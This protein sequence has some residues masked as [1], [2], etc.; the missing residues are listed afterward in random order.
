MSRH[1][2]LIISLHADPIQPSGTSFGGGTHAYIRELIREITVSQNHCL[3]ITRSTGNDQPAVQR[4]SDFGKICRIVIGQN[5]HMDKRFLNNFHKET[6]IAIQEVLR[7][8]KFNPNILHSV[9]WNSGRAAYDLSK[10]LR[11]PYVHTV[12]SN[13]K[14]RLCQGLIDN[15]ESR[16]EIERIVFEKAFAIISI[17][18][19]EKKDLVRFYTIPANKIFVV[20][21]PVAASFITPSQD[22]IGEPRI[23]L[24][25]CYGAVANILDPNELKKILA[26]PTISNR[27]FTYVGRIDS[28][29][30][31]PEIIHA[32]R[33]L[34]QIY[35]FRCPGL[36][37]IGGNPKDIQ[38]FR[39]SAT[40]PNDLHQFET[41]SDII[42][43]GYLDS[44]GISA[45]LLKAFA[46]V[47]HSI[48]E[49]G[50]RVIL[51]AMSQGVPVIATPFG[52]AH[53]L[54]EDWVSG[55]LVDYGDNRTLQ[56]RLDHFIQQP[57]L[58]AAL[59][60]NAKKR[61]V[62]ALK[63]WDFQGKHFLLY[64]KAI[65]RGSV[66]PTIPSGEIL[67]S[68]DV[69]NKRMVLPQHTNI[70]GNSIYKA[71]LGLHKRI[72]GINA[73]D[74]IQLDSIAGKA[75]C[76]KTT[77]GDIRLFFK[78][79]HSHFRE[80][81]LWL[82]TG[83]EMLVSLA[84]E[85]IKNEISAS[86]LPG[87]IKIIDFD[88]EKLLVAKHWM[89][90]V[91]FD[92]SASDCARIFLAP[93]KK[94]WK[95]DVVYLSS[96]DRAILEINYPERYSDNFYK[97]IRR[98]RKKLDH[99]SIKNYN[100]TS[101]LSIFLWVPFISRQISSNTVLL[102]SDIK[103]DF[104]SIL[105]ILEEWIVR[106]KEMPIVFSHGSIDKNHYLKTSRGEIFITDGETLHRG[107]WGR[108]AG[109]ILRELLILFPTQPVSDFLPLL[110]Q[111]GIRQ[112]LILAWAL[113]VELNCLARNWTLIFPDKYKRAKKR[114]KI[115]VAEVS[116][117]NEAI[118]L[119]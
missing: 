88:F 1:R 56:Q 84:D 111:N 25:P 100:N 94:L 45:V 20:G 108:D 113:L 32:W 4:I 79:F 35:K 112:R 5:D 118:R 116:K 19:Q 36:W 12:I 92:T 14:R 98:L 119:S 80:T 66:L 42:W 61:A 24:C 68:T 90:G 10:K 21:R 106:E 48:Y 55:F 29:K 107:F 33:N 8:E 97:I 93:L 39:H 72:T 17:T 9:Y 114:W 115:L 38:K 110:E 102:E 47:T 30:G 54:I 74:I 78:H 6:I 81:P 49:P 11:V 64:D 27:F 104:F 91:H 26:S 57:H 101:F 96:L 70:S 95:Y 41:Q 73:D 51:E 52:F 31:L 63:N 85:K 53:D 62:S 7:K 60:H 50:G 87:F 105:P 22:T 2:V 77:S 3:V 37:I 99:P 117:M 109:E 40:L 103:N 43:W 58:S 69:L 89:E 71:I 18:E 15:A 13:G 67:N 65:S 46:L 16:L 28:N 44:P 23:E 75:A 82:R 76:W 86:H 59:G 34:K 83:K